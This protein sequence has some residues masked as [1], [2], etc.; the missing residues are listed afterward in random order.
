[1]ADRYPGATWLTGG[2]IGADQIATDELLARGE[3]V[4]L[5]VPGAAVRKHTVRPGESPLRTLS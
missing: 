5:R 2:A 3:R 4:V 1:V